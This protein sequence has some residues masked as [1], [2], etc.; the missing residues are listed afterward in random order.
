MALDLHLQFQHFNDMICLMLLLLLEH[1]KYKKYSE[2]H[3]KCIFSKSKCFK[4][5]S[6]SPIFSP[7]RFWSQNG[8]TAPLRPSYFQAILG[9]PGGLQDSQKSIEM[10]IIFWCFFGMPPGR[11]PGGF[12]KPNWNQN[13]PKWPQKWIQKRQ[14]APSKKSQIL[15]RRNEGNM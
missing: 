10:D 9:G 15:Q 2:I 14:I 3:A 7:N 1:K 5:T 12:W 13:H 6:W 11:P 4:F 8:T